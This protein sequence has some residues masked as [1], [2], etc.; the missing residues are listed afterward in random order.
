MEDIALDVDTAVPIGLILN[1]LVTNAWKYAWPGVRTG[2]LAVKLEREA[3][4]L[5]MRVTDDGVAAVPLPMKIPP[6][7]A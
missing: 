3:E 4:F 6:G 1:E 2:V 7:S 5:F